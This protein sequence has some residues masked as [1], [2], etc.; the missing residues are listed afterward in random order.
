MLPVP[1]RVRPLRAWLLGM[2]VVLLLQLPGQ[3]AAS[4][5]R[6]HAR[7]AMSSIA[8]SSAAHRPMAFVDRI[9]KGR[10][11]RA[12]ARRAQAR[13]ARRPARRRANVR[14]G[15]R[16]ATSCA[17]KVRRRALKVERGR[18]SGRDEALACAAAACELPTVDAITD[19]ITGTNAEG[20]RVGLVAN[21]QIHDRSAGAAQDI[22][23][24]TGAGWLR[25]EF[26]W[27]LIEPRND[28]WD[29]S[30]YDHVIE[31]AAVRGMRVLPLLNGSASWAAPTWNQFPDDPAEYAEY[32]AAVTERYGPGG[33]FWRDRPAL[34]RL[35]PTHFELWNEPYIEYFSVDRVDPA[36]YARL[37]RAAASAGR[38]A[39]SGARFLLAADTFYTAAPGDY[40]NWIDGM[41]EAVPDLNA[42]FD[43]VA[44]HPYSAGL[45]P[46]TYTPGKGTRWQF[47]RIEEMRARF[48]A[49]GG[50]AKRF[51]I[52][53]LGWATCS[54]HEDCVAESRQADYLQRAFDYV[55]GPY[56]AFTEAVFVYHLNDWGPTDQ[57]DK[58]FWFGLLRRDGS[59]K[60][61]FEVLRR[62]AGLS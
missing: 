33:S 3:A 18:A 48:V 43:A 5:D 14:A 61:A 60:P 19:T 37:V 28:V 56:A 8:T 16:R 41:Y 10:L 24:Q 42:H 17:R 30:R 46:D 35:A 26:D 40:R 22:A 12:K 53:E 23:A 59:R 27:S 45:S 39:N 49:H 54:A 44:I 34:A 38:A 55:R 4:A 11:C 31:Q 7:A 62:A 36:R 25:E 20:L 9:G 29:W 57:S 13:A 6:E 2:V 1:T 47:R 58:E 52:T 15:G 32:V 51:W 50:A 21:T